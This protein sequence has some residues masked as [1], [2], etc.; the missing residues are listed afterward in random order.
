[1]LHVTFGPGTVAP[2][3]EAVQAM[4]AAV[5]GVERV[6]ALES[7]SKSHYA[8]EVLAGADIRASL[9]ALAVEQGLILLELA[10]ERTNLEEVFRRLTG[11]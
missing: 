1:M 5:D 3:H 9:F 7:A 8:F 6:T 4:V 11:N 2:T 10:P